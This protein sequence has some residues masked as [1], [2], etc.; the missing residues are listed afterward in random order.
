MRIRSAVAT[1]MAIGL[2]LSLGLPASAQEAKKPATAATPAPAPATPAAPA[3]AGSTGQ[4][5]QAQTDA[6]VFDAGQLASI[7][8][9]ADYFN[10]LN[11]LKSDFQQTNPDGKKMRGKLIVKRPGRFR[12]DYNKPSRQIVISDGKML[13]IQDLDGNSD[14]RYE[15][16]N[17]PFRMLLK[18]DVD[19]VRDARI[20]DVQEA[21]DL[22]VLSVMDKS[23]DAPG[24]IKL[25][26]SVKPAMELKEWVT[27]DA[28][29]LDTRV[30][31]SGVN[32][33]EEVD[34]KEFDI[35]SVALGKFKQ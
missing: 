31:L 26:F 15:L 28:Q 13:A 16:D 8:K 35:K 6:R 14:D 29:N 24:R 34:A 3:A 32:R 5:W 7:K 19:L 30:E 10:A 27:T 33:A 1:M 23:P 22:I 20:L 17:T 4:A 2:G 18:K 9:V 11:N 25:F 12:F 21:E